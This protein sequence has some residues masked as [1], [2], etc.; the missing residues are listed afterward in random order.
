MGPLAEGDIY[1][2]DD[3]S[4]DAAAVV[5]ALTRMGSVEVKRERLEAERI[6]ATCVVVP[7][8][9][10][11]AGLADLRRIRAAGY[12]GAI[13]FYASA[14]RPEVLV[15]AIAAGAQDVLQP[16]SN[17]PDGLRRAV[18]SAIVRQRSLQ[19]VAADVRRQWIYDR[20]ME[21]Q[22]LAKVG[23]WEI[24]VPTWSVEWSPEFRRIMSVGLDEPPLELEGYASRVHPLDRERVVSEL[25]GLLQQ[26]RP[27]D[28]EH[29][30]VHPDGTELYVHAVGRC[31][32]AEDGAVLRAYG[33]TQDITERKQLEMALSELSLRDELTQ[34]RNRRG[35][36][37]LAEQQL[38]MADRTTETPALFF[39]DLNGMKA[40]NDTLGHEMGDHALRATADILRGVFGSL[41]IVARL[42]GDEFV[43]LVIDASPRT[44]EELSDRLRAEVRA[45]NES[46]GRPFVL[47]ISTG[48][49]L[50]DPSSPKTIDVM[51]A[52]ADE[53]MYEAK[54]L[55]K[56]SGHSMPV[57]TG[58]RP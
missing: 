11:D 43:A 27:F 28:S 47:S 53:R 50:Y 35:F 21:A 19:P 41:D 51:L 37:T 46:A 13:V 58:A 48:F 10:I 38:K 4:L 1:V 18:L 6:D 57:T 36:T 22:S 34:L 40:I 5:R 25:L 39:I 12:A 52:E 31:V 15:A 9:P 3:G 30:L 56:A 24:D 33:T 7:L 14:A 54:R 17:T 49:S 32:R 45:F 26:A 20:F 8:G 23:S 55:R 16:V 42:G 29:R 2:V 44:V